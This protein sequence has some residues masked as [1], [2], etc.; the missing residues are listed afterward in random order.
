MTKSYLQY[1]EAAGITPEP[2]DRKFRKDGKNGAKG[3]ISKKAFVFCPI[4]R[5][6]VPYYFANGIE[7]LNH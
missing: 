1:C 3:T 5:T 6:K 4:P 2:P 7:N